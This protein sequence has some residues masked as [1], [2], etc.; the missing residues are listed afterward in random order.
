MKNLTEFLRGH[1]SNE[2]SEHTHTKIGNRDLN[3]FGGKYTIPN[4][5]LPLFYKFYN[6]AI[7]ENG[8][9]EYLTER[10]LQ[11]GK[12]SYTNPGPILVDLDFRYDTT[13][14][15]RQHSEDHLMDII[16][17]YMT[18]LQKILDIKP[19]V[20]IPVYILE[21][22]TVN[23]LHDKTKDGI[24]IVIGIHPFSGMVR[25]SELI[26]HWLLSIS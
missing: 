1:I 25:L 21:K 2:H 5:D 26:I 7:F 9:K 3:I 18:N 8:K 13:I 16:E 12:S 14:T 4:E 17:I 6:E 22:P 20:D 15:T 11:E 24:H 23:M 10:Q 19:D